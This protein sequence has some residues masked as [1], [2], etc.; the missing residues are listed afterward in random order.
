MIAR[1]IEFA[2]ALALALAVAA[3]AAATSKSPPASP[4]PPAGEVQKPAPPETRKP[5]AP[6]AQKPPAEGTQKPT[7]PV[8]EKAAPPKPRVATSPDGTKIAYEVA[9]AGP[10][11]VLL[12]GGGQTRRSWND[13][14]Y[15]DRLSKRFTV[16]TLDLR[17]GGDSDKPTRADAYALDRHLTDVLTVADA[18]G[19]KRFH[20]W[21]FGHGATL[22]RYLA[23]RSDR[24]SAAVLVG[25]GM[26]PAVSGIVKDAIVAM[27]AKWQPLLEA[28]ARGELDLK[29]LS[30]GDRA[31]L[32]GSV[33]ITAV[34]LGAFLDYPP[35]EPADLKAPTLWLIGSEDRAATANV[36]EYEGRLA[37]TSVT[38]K[39]LTGVTYSDSF[40]KIEPILAEAEPFLAAAGQP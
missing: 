13:L 3:C 20:V 15:V 12:H 37:G 23:A 19:A 28:Q 25:T 33:A 18:A 26:G 22:A 16:I 35:L 7:A 29:T 27:R 6:A 17:G 21:G 34:A 9:G 39:Q 38:L 32:D 8:T 10:A 24:V 31:A 14:G 30:P 4:T 11:L 2:C 1:P 40:V 36:K 5:P